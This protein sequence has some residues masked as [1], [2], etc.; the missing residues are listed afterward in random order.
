MLVKRLS[1]HT[2][3]HIYTYICIIGVNRKEKTKP[4]TVKICIL[5]GKIGKIYFNFATKNKFKTST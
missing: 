5:K 4:F 1:T 2:N 3:T